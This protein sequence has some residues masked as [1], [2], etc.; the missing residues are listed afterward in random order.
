MVAETDALQHI[1]FLIAD[2]TMEVAN[3]RLS[4]TAKL[5]ENVALHSRRHIEPSQTRL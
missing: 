5:I 1:G 3:D 4:P 2:L